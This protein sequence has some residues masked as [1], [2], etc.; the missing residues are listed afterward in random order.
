VIW[1]AARAT[2]Y[3]ENNAS[4]VFK[5]YDDLFSLCQG[6]RFVAEYYSQSTIVSFEA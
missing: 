2:Y 5:V 6:D 4:R 1:D 3:L